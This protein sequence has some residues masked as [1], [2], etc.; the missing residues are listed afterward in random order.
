MAWPLAGL[1]SPSAFSGPP[2]TRGSLRENGP[3]KYCS[4]YETEQRQ[5]P[6]ALTLIKENHQ[7]RGFVFACVS[8]SLFCCCI[9]AI[10][11]DARQGHGGG[12]SLSLGRRK[13]SQHSALHWHVSPL[14]VKD[15]HSFA[16]GVRGQICGKAELRYTP[17]AH[18]PLTQQSKQFVKFTSKKRRFN[19]G[20]RECL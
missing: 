10:C 19:R 4:L 3:C 9:S 14:L 5:Q 8:Q 12:R 2:L 6:S 1:C 15:I 20:R 18:Y 13:K 17:K 16:L 7:K 11:V